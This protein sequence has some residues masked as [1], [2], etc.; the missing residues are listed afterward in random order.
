MSVNSTSTPSSEPDLRPDQKGLR[1]LKLIDAAKI[2]RVEPDLR[3]DQKGLRPGRDVDGR[4]RHANRTSDLIRRDCDNFSK[5]PECFVSQNRTSDLIRRDCDRFHL[6]ILMT[7]TSEPDLRPDQKGLRL[8]AEY[9]GDGHEDRN[10]TSDLIR[11][12][13]DNNAANAKIHS[14]ANRTSDLIRRDC[15]IPSSHSTLASL[16]GTGPQT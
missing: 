11:R 1:L 3:P 4:R 10:R 7:I 15:D 13:C 6:S 5:N 8:T 2:F 14:M 9:G 12:D 16:C